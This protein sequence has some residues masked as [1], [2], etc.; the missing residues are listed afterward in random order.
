MKDALSVV[1]MVVLRVASSVDLKVG[2]MDAS[3]VVL[4][5]M[6]MRKSHGNER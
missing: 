3:L 5:P 1:V 6:K 4:C 2:K